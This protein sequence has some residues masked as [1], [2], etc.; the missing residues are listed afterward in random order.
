MQDKGAIRELRLQIWHLQK[1]MLP[2]V[3]F[4]LVASESL[5]KFIWGLGIRSHDV[6]L[7]V[8]HFEVNTDW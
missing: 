5:V 6:E 1:G 7:T 8:K 3:C 4:L 2:A